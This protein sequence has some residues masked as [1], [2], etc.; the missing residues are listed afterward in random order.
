MNAPNSFEM[1]SVGRL[2]RAEGSGYV[3]RAGRRGKRCAQARRDAAVL[4]L[5]PANCLLVALPVH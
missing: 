3:L 2:A 4:A 5:W 1:L